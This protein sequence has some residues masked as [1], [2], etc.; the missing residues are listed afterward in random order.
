M[1]SKDIRGQRGASLI[2]VPERV[3]GV[4]YREM[5][6]LTEER[7][8]IFDDNIRL[9]DSYSNKGF[10]W[11]TTPDGR[12]VLRITRPKVADVYYRT[13]SLQEIRS[14]T[15]DRQNELGTIVGTY[16]RLN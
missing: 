4:D 2:L 11:D 7:P 13:V 5:F 9:G 3:R 12:F 16:G 8:W 1:T 14:F 10:L 15:L 6:G